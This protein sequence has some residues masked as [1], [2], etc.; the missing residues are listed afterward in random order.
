MSVFVHLKVIVIKHTLGLGVSSD[1][2][3]SGTDGTGDAVSGTADKVLDLTSSLLSLTLL[4][5]A[6]SLGLERRRSDD[7]TDELLAGANQ[8]VLLAIDA[9]R[10]GDG[11][12]G[13]RE[14]QGADIGTSIGSRLLGGGY[15][16]EVGSGLLLGGVTCGMLEEQREMVN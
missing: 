13:S 12:T 5:L 14:I 9:V 11:D 8:L 16:F 10:V 7:I 15:L 2:G 6:T 1:T 3:D 4:V